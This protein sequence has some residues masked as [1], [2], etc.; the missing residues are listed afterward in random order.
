M[1]E[2]SHSGEA[3]DLK[4]KDRKSPLAFKDPAEKPGEPEKERQMIGRADQVYG[5]QACFVIDPAN[6]NVNA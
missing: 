1:M 6:G 2:E 3:A 5:V 4:N